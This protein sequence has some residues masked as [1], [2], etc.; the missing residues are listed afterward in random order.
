MLND[1]LDNLQILKMLYEHDESFICDEEE[2]AEKLASSLSSFS[3]GEASVGFNVLHL[4]S[5][6]GLS[7]TSLILLALGMEPTSSTDSQQELTVFRRF[8]PLHLAAMQGH[9]HLFKTFLYYFK[10]QREIVQY[11]KRIMKSEAPISPSSFP[12]LP[13]S[14][15]HNNPQSY[16]SIYDYY[17]NLISQPV[18]IELQAKEE[19]QKALLQQDILGDT[20]LKTSTEMFNLLLNKRN[21]DGETVL[22]V[23]A[24][25]RKS[26]VIE[27]ILELAKHVNRSVI[28]TMRM[29]ENG[30]LDDG[31]DDDD[32]EDDESTE[33]D[34][35]DS[36]DSDSVS[37]SNPNGKSNRKRKT[38]EDHL[39]RKKRWIKVDEENDN[40]MTAL[41]V[42]SSRGFGE[43]VA[44]FASYN[45]FM[46]REMRYMLDEEAALDSSQPSSRSRQQSEDEVEAYKSLRTHHL[47][48]VFQ[49]DFGQLDKK[50]SRD[51]VLHLACQS[52]LHRVFNYNYE[53]IEDHYACVY[54]VITRMPHHL[55]LSA[56]NMEGDAALD[57][58]LITAADLFEN[59]YN[60]SLLI[61]AVNKSRL[62]EKAQRIEPLWSAYPTLR[63]FLDACHD[64]EHAIR[65]VSL[66]QIFAQLNAAQS[67]VI[68]TETERIS[69]PSPQAPRRIANIGSPN[70]S[71]H[72]HHH[73]VLKP[74]PPIEEV[75]R[76]GGALYNILDEEIQ[77]AEN[78]NA[79]CKLIDTTLIPNTRKFAHVPRLPKTVISSATSGASPFDSS[80][81]TG[82]A[83]PPAGHP[84]IS[85]YPLGATCPMGFGKKAEN[86][87]TSQA[88]PA[89]HPDVSKYPPGATCPMGF[90]YKPSTPSPS[91]GN[92][93]GGSATA[94]SSSSASASQ[95]PPAGH[96]DISKYPPGAVCPMGFGRKSAATTSAT[97]VS[98][99][100]STS[101]STASTT[102]PAS[103][104]PQSHTTSSLRR[105]IFS[106]DNIILFGTVGLLAGIALYRF[107][108]PPSLTTFAT[109]KSSGSSHMRHSSGK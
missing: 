95:A 4:A 65:S 39:Q 47:Q 3:W 9:V 97:H 24:Y 7:L 35:S 82:P 44:L 5:S 78:A 81:S 11:I 72:R 48:D 21:A 108:S 57:L 49:A 22:H 69:S 87:P 66:L 13:T 37:A 67:E 73:V 40:G 107:I 2:E 18:N 93:Q 105:S 12:L 45:E 77:R 64:G 1:I 91:E 80:S 27:W 83:E 42:A 19:L 88:P 63:A 98:E 10:N 61:H 26:P 6:L 101:T 86:V 92:M 25:H 8:S 100:A 46:E 54:Q 60:I 109:I 43:I 20:S 23:A 74:T 50:K 90:G 52:Q 53:L 15:V 58:L 34:D 79:P 55:R 85:K 28:A 16:R 29:S 62:A 32:D 36:D 103:D 89:G 68:G 99:S 30:L 106:Y 59:I 17:G 56:R 33:S 84:D 96:P 41:M 51:T 71:S 70:E 76:L 75:V 38:L 104:T 31:D 102:S 14:F 94:S